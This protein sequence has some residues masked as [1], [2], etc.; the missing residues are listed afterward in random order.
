MQLKPEF[1]INMCLFGGSDG[2]EK[3]MNANVDPKCPEEVNMILE[4]DA[5]NIVYFVLLSDFS[6]LM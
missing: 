6:F 4:F 3:W 5:V 2:F 1:A